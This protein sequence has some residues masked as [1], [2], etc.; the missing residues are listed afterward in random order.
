[1]RTA[2]HSWLMFAI[3][4][5]PIPVK[6]HHSMLLYDSGR[7][8]RIEGTISNVFF[9]R[10]H[11]RYEIVVDSGGESQMW[12]M[13]AQ[14][15][16]DARRFGYYDELATIEVGAT[17]EIEGWP[18][19]NKPRELLGHWV[20]SDVV[21]HVELIPR[22]GYARPPLYAA[23]D[24]AVIDK[25]VLALVVADRAGEDNAATLERWILS[26]H[27]IARA[28]AEVQQ[29]RARLVAMVSGGERDFVGMPR[30]LACQTA[31][32]PSIEISPGALSGWTEVARQK[33]EGWV[34]TYNRVLA[35]HWELTLSSCGN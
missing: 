23:M 12:V 8:E 18:H 24:R 20:R 9:G 34:S 2:I 19:R 33:F 10:P 22:S 4:L 26:D 21:G 27:P 25:R 1:M 32:R 35:K 30:Y 11:S 31:I 29:D 14:D 28:G 6:A 17:V 13:I 3:V 15:P 7:L 5:F 16:E